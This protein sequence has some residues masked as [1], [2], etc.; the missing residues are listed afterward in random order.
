ML[1]FYVGQFVKPFCVRPQ[2]PGILVTAQ[3]Y[4]VFVIYACVDGLRQS[5][6]FLVLMESAIFGYAGHWCAGSGRSSW[7]VN[8]GSFGT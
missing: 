2:C 5:A 3:R 4:D 1:I 8:L 7:L 6:K